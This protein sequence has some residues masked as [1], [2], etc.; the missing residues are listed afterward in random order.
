MP[1]RTIVLTLAGPLQ[2]WGSSQ[3]TET[4]RTGLYPTK[5]AIIGMIAGA[6]G[7]PS[8]SPVDDLRDL[9][10]TVRVD[11]HG[12]VVEDF[13]TARMN[14]ELKGVQARLRP[15]NHTQITKRE[16]RSEAVYTVFLT[17]DREL[18]E[19]VHDALLHP[20]YAPFL[21]RRAAV[22]SRPVY[23]ANSV[24]H[25]EEVSELLSSVPWSAPDHVRR[26]ADD[27][28]SLTVIRDANPGETPHGTV[29][30]N[31]VNVREYL[32]RPV[33]HDTVTV[34]VSKPHRTRVVQYHGVSPFI[35]DPDKVL[36]PAP[37]PHDPFA[38]I[39]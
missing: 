35:P 9:R 1:T 19:I 11:H 27:E 23:P 15:A 21:G 39:K 6:L 34:Q 2:S 37:G 5:S 14:V 4:R 36:R 25:E 18:I 8:G 16:F 32:P 20:V 13:H 30:D 10:F 7:R 26:Y 33:V 12:S 24:I 29:M 22:P 31:P 38:L 28:V 3:G 17:G